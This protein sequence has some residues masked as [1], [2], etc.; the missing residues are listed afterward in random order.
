MVKAKFTKTAFILSIL[1]F[2]LKPV[3]VIGQELRF[4][5]EETCIS[6]G[7]GLKFDCKKEKTE[8]T[9][10]K[11]RSSYTGINSVDGTT[12]NLPVIE[13]TRYRTVLANPVFFDGTSQIHFTKPDNRFYWIEVAYSD[14]LKAREVT[15]RSGLKISR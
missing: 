14:L 12:Y 7:S 9:I 15:I 6:A 2:T 10:V 8:F 3:S 1:F 5:I 11:N 4:R 13:D